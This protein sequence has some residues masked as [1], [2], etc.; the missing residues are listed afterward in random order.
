[1]F[2]FCGNSRKKPLPLVMGFWGRILLVRV[3]ILRK[4]LI[5]F[6]VSNA[7]L[8]RVEFWGKIQSYSWLDSKGEPIFVCIWN[9]RENP[10]PSRWDFK[11]NPFLFKQE[12]WGRIYSCLCIFWM[13]IHSYSWWDSGGQTTLVH[14]VIPRGGSILFS[15]GIPR[16]SDFCLCRDF[17]GLSL[18]FAVRF[19]RESI[20]PCRA[21]CSYRILCE[22]M[23]LFVS[24][25]RTWIS[26][27][28]PLL[29]VFRFRGSIFLLGFGGKI[30]SC[31]Y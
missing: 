14:V 30:W 17:E 10:L 2:F 23:L 29:H 26:G 12:F 6:V 31:F 24:L 25:V 7:F 5:Q 16:V 19:Q 1:M 20:C 3:G 21:F 13:E 11:E 18:Q 4:N 28:N 15:G 27:E 22:D 8:F 9:S